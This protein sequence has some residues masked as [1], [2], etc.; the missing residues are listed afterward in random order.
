MTA[1]FMLPVARHFQTCWTPM[2]DSVNNN[3][4]LRYDYKFTSTLLLHFLF[5][6]LTYNKI[7]GA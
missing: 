3:S 2:L 4:E 1:L 6:K 5:K 7:I